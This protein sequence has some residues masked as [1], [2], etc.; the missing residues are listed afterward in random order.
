MIS[1]ENWTAFPFFFFFL[2]DRLCSYVICYLPVSK[3]TQASLMSMVVQQH[4]SESRVP[5]PNQSGH[6]LYILCVEVLGKGFSVR[7]DPRQ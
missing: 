2:Y 3:F 6:H 1:T 7:S 4:V 5:V